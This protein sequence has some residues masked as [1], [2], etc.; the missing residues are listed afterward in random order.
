MQSKRLSPRTLVHWLRMS[1]G[2]LAA[3]FSACLLAVPA[4]SRSLPDLIVTDVQMIPAAPYA[5][6]TVRFQM[7]VANQGAAPTPP[8]VVIG[9]IF[10]LNGQ[11]IAYE[12]KDTTS[13]A[14]GGSVVVMS[15]GGGANADGT[16]VAQ[17]GT[18]TLSAYIDDVNR[19]KESN[20]NN[21]YYANPNPITIIV[22]SGADLIVSDVKFSP[23]RV[24]PR[25]P[26]LFR[27]EVTNIGNVTTPGN[28]PITMQF[29]VDGNVVS[30][31]NYLKTLL[32]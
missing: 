21:N 27:A 32:S 2:A 4:L 25:T 9:G 31:N 19:I 16:W 13:L 5:G 14:P 8:G 11:V 18:F 1:A 12:D 17:A 28:I 7:T 23:K 29:T 26:I 3:L 20:E 15:N 22:K 10:M 24:G 6:D 30:E